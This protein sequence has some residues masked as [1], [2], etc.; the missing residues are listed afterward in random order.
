MKYYLS[1]F[2]PS[3]I[4]IILAFFFLWYQAL[5][6]F[7]VVGSLVTFSILYAI[8]ASEVIQKNLEKNENQKNNNTNFRVITVTMAKSVG[9]VKKSDL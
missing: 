2:L 8:K 3:F 7:I 9:W 4:S 1:V 6:V 5:T